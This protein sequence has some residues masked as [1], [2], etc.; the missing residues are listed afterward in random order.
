MPL[1]DVDQ[2]IGLFV[3][4]QALCK[5]DN[6][7]ERFDKEYRFACVNWMNAKDNLKH[8]EEIEKKMRQEL[9]EASRSQNSKGFGVRLEKITRKGPVDYSAVPDLIGL[10]LEK[11]RKPA[12]ESWRITKEN[13]DE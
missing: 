3:E 5:K 9:I 10:D 2:D 4:L 6:C 7:E 8:A 1:I 11:Y 12:S 13:D